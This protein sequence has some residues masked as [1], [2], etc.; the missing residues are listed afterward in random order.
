[1]PSL[2]AGVSLI[3]HGWNGRLTG[4]VNTAAAD[5]THA[6]RA[7]ARCA[8]H[9]GDPTTAEGFLTFKA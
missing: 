9:D 6:L 2:F 5:I 3:T 4:F 1:M 7:V 8:V